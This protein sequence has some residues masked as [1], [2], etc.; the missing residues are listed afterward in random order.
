[1]TGRA[2]APADVGADP[3]ALVDLAANPQAWDFFAAAAIAQATRPGAPGPGRAG[4]I[5]DEPVRLGQRPTLSLAA[6]PVARA[7]WTERAGRRVF[8]IDQVAFGPFGATGAL[9]LHVTVDAMAEERAKRPWLTGF[10]DLFTHRMTGFLVRAWQASRPAASRALGRDDPFPRIVASLYGMGPPE[11]EGRDA[12]PDDT[13]RFAAG[14]LSGGRRSAAAA[15]GLARVV[16]GAPA[17][18]EEFVPEWLPI[19]ADEQARP[20]LGAARLGQDAVVG[21]RAW[22]VTTRLRLRLGPLDFATFD[23][24]LPGGPL[25]DRLDAA[26]R[27][28]FGFGRVWDVTLAL[29][30]EAAPAL[31][32]DGAGRLGFDSWLVPR[33]DGTH[34]DVTLA[35]PGGA[36]AAAPHDRHA[37]GSI[38]A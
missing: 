27:Q 29:R 7:G 10:L 35:A 36:P 8:A 26:L 2:A 11:F 20:G 18:V 3:A 31:R 4:R 30:A 38:A 14:W 28:L 21:P 25:A 19:R 6:A 1:M 23:A 32:L 17:A 15:A 37:N 12:L 24:L 34:E 9:P 5:E 22:S 33:R 13:R 16:T